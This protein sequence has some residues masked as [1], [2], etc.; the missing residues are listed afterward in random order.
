MDDR[1]KQIVEGLQ[2]EIR[3]LRKRIEQL[4]N[5]NRRLRE[6]L[7]QAQTAAARQTA[8]F[9]RD[10]NKKIPPQ[11]HKQPGQKPGHKGFFRKEPE[12]IDEIIEVPLDKCPRCN[13]P[14]SDC[15]KLEQIIEEIPPIRPHVVK[16]ITYSG[17]CQ[18]CGRVRSSHP[19]QTSVGQGAAKVQL[20]PRAL[21]LAAALNKVHGL[22]MR[23][24]CKVLKDL[25]GLRVT[26]GGLS[27]ALC[28][29]AGR[30]RWMYGKF[31]D[32][33]R[34]SPAVFADETSW[35]VGSPGW[36]LWVFT[37]ANGTV[38]RVDNSRGSKV[39]DD[40]LGREF[41]G[42]LVSDCL[43]S[44]DPCDYA[45]HKCIAH[46]LRAI[47]K[48]MSLPGTEETSYLSNWQ[49]FFKAVIVL[50]GMR[51]RLS[52][53]EFFEKRNRMEIWCDELFGSLSSQPG[54]IA[55]KNRL[56]KQRKHLLG[57]LYEPSAEPTNNRA[58]RALRPAVIA[59]KLSCG[60]K[61]ERGCDCWQILTSVAATCNQ[62]MI[63][64]VD[65]LSGQLS[66][67]AQ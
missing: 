19:L 32:D 29:V 54:D 28:R 18:R 62:R 55:V 31:T 36:W 13:R 33:I 2:T 20:G 17:S 63:D 45:K 46:H 43:S 49:I 4:E 47:S 6:Q 48:A 41:K 61:T 65:Y 14:V 52:K 38:Y 21:S 22:T 57:C 11:E 30:V 5:E 56:G 24:T 35:Y 53:D 1:T 8:P 59:R 58:E 60:N 39:V 40:V 34:A 37:N 16:L 42:M 50:Y 26:A 51:Q 23:R 9:R 10:E 44:Y 67:T 66:L 27:Q 64:F 15:Q 12:H 25:C 7:E 3:R